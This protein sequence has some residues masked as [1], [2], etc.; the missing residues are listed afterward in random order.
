MVR[1]ASSGGPSEFLAT[2]IHA[3]KILILIAQANITFRFKH[4]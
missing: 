1:R 3:T 4:G 2:K